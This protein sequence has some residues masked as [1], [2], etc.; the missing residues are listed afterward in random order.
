MMQMAKRLLFVVLC[1]AFST[2]AWAGSSGA[3]QAGVFKKVFTFNKA[4]RGKKV[5]VLAVFNDS[6]KA[7]IDEVVAGF[8]GKGISVKALPVGDLAGAIGPGKVVYTLS[9][10]DVVGGL[11]A[12]K[13]VLSITGDLALVKA[14][15]LSVSVSDNGGKSLIS[16]NL[17]RTKSEGQV[18][19]PTFLKLAKI[20]R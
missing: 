5:Q 1:L 2:P 14:G 18:F 11:C 4:L 6:T 20:I 3:A 7:A 19:A 8:S 17:P 15:K 10:A 9:D 13:K 12:D 16:V